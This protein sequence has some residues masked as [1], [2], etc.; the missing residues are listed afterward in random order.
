MDVLHPCD[1]LE[2]EKMDVNIRYSHMYNVVTYEQIPRAK[3]YQMRLNHNWYWVYLKH[4]NWDL[5]PQK[6][7]TRGSWIPLPVASWNWDPMY[8]HYTHRTINY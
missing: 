4:L 1:W 3:N 6:K 7:S 2:I 8:N 5:F